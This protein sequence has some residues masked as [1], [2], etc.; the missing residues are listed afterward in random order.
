MDPVAGDYDGDGA[1]DIAIL[2][3]SNG[4]W[5]IQGVGNKEQ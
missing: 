2:R 1:T 4:K 3:P 5:Y